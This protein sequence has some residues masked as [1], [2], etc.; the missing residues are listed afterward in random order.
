MT[1]TAMFGSSCSS[2][3]PELVIFA[4]AG[5]KT[6][7]DEVCQKFEEQY[8]AKV[9]INYGGGGEVLSQMMLSRIGDVYVAPEQGFM[10]TA[11]KEQVIEPERMKF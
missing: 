6:P 9:I 1:I 7:L 10:E 5:A 11:A 4:A 2:T 3:Q 8:H